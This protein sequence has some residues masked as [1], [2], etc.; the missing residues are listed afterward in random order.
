MRKKLKKQLLISLCCFSLISLAVLLMPL[1]GERETLT[2]RGLNCAVGI[3]FW[4]GL[5]SGILSCVFIH[6]KNRKY[7][8]VHID[9]GRRPAAVRFFSTRAAVPADSVLIVSLI[10]VIAGNISKQFHPAADYIFLFLF[11]TALYLHFLANSNLFHYIEQ[12]TAKKTGR[13]KKNEG[14]AE[15]P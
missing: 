10:G 12:S 5:L 6:R 13:R 15:H 1:A 4:I 14:E 9:K 3:L 11:V 2:Q 7:L 8:S